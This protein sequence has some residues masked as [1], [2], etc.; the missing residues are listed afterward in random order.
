MRKLSRLEYFLAGYLKKCGLP[1]H[2]IT[3]DYNEPYKYYVNYPQGNISKRLGGSYQT[4]T[5]IPL[6]KEFVDQVVIIHRLTEF[7]SE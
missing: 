3:L 7:L 6:V 1:S 2:L 5:N 4:K